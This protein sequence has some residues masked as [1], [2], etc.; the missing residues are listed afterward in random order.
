[1]VCMYVYLYAYV[2]EYTSK[3]FRGTNINARMY[4]YIH[5][6]KYMFLSFLEVASSHTHIR[7]RVHIHLYT[8]ICMRRYLCLLAAALDAET[9]DVC[10]HVHTY[11]HAYIPS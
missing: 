11:I 10:I 7:A 2:F 9:R 5:A 1:M 6:C 4:T 8:H 3:H